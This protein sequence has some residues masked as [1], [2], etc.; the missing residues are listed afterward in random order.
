MLANRV[1]VT[2]IGVISPLGLDTGSTWKNLLA[3]KSGVDQITAFD[4]EGHG[5]TIAAEVKGFDPEAL[6][7][8]KQA[9]RMDRFVQLGASAALEAIEA[10]EFS[11][12][13]EN[14]TRV[15]VMMA[16]GIGGI[17]TLESQIEVLGNRGPNRISPFPRADDAAR[18]GIGADFNAAGREGAEL[19]HSIGLL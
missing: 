17:I 16:S 6:L 2:G 8:R 11:V 13:E 12:T 5:T 10:A 15:S 4:P 18:H 1:V 19:Q 7:G 14:Q 9:R 3:G